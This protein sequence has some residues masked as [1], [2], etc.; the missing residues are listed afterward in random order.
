MLLALLLS[1]VALLTLLPRPVRALPAA[2]LPVTSR[3]YNYLCPPVPKPLS[4]SLEQCWLQLDALTSGIL[5]DIKDKVD[6]VDVCF[7]SVSTGQDL[8]SYGKQLIVS[9]RVLR[10]LQKENPFADVKLIN[11][12]Q[13][14]LID[15]LETPVICLPDLSPLF[16]CDKGK[17]VKKRSLGDTRK[18]ALKTVVVFMEVIE[19]MYMRSA[20]KKF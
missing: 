18:E 12:I 19:R 10:C 2:L 16:S 14:N 15:I 11:K 13:L 6:D 20:G 17:T 1:S 7:G 3:P 4:N 8:S 9:F 5:D